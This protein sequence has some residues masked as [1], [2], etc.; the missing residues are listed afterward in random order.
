[1]KSR[2]LI[3]LLCFA[4]LPLCAE[5]TAVPAQQPAPA[6][7]GIVRPQ[8]YA[9]WKLISVSQRIEQGTVRAI[10]GNQAAHDAAAAGKTNPWPD[11]V[12]LVKTSWKQRAHELYPNAMVPGEFTQLDFMI[13][14]SKKYAATAGWGFA[15]WVGMEQKPYGTDV[16]FAQECVACHSIAK[17]VDYV[18]THPVKLP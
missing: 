8:D 13:K 9:S 3:P 6:P 18:F 11:G 15:R 17:D 4:S 2:F 14:D 10:L 12:I 5:E 7:N 1:M 16:N